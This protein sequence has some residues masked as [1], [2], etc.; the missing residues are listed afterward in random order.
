MNKIRPESKPPAGKNRLS[1]EKSPY[2]LQHAGNPVDWYPW[3]EEAFDRAKSEDKPVFLSI[4]YSTCHWCHVMAHE[5][6][7]DPGVAA[8]MNE[9]FINVKVDREERPDID[10]VYMP[11]CQMVRGNGGWPLTVIL[12]PDKA[13]FFVATYLPRES[14]RGMTGMLDLVPHIGKLWREK[15]REVDDS[16]AELARH[17]ADVFARRPGATAPGAETLDAA[18]AELSARFDEA[19]AGFGRAPKFP[20]PHTL[21]FLLRYWRRTGETRALY[22]VER[23]LGHMARGGICDQVGFGF[24]RYSTDERWFAPHFE[25][26]LY[27]QALLAMAYAECFLATGKAEY[28]RTAEEILLYIMRDMTDPVGGFFSAEDADSEGVEGKYYLWTKSEIEALLGGDDARLVIDLYGVEP[29]GNFADEVAGGNI[30]HLRRP[31]E[32][33]A[34]ELGVEPEDLRLRIDRIRAVLLEARN[35]RVRPHRDDKILADW[36]GLMIAALSVAARAFGADEYS[37]AAEKAARF[38]LDSM[39][40]PEGGLLHRYREGEAAV[41]GN[42]DDH[43]FL[44]WGLMELYET[45]FDAEHLETAVQ[46]T[47]EMIR[48]FADQ[49]HGG[50][51]FTRADGEAMIVR[52]R[53]IYDGAIPSGNSAA[54]VNLVRLARLTG[55]ARYEEHAARIGRVFFEDLSRAPSGYSWYM[56]S[57]ELAEGPSIE[58]VVVGDPASSDTRSMLREVRA[59]YAPHAAILFKTS[60]G[61]DPAIGRIAPFTAAHT[62][63]DGRATAYICRNHACGAPTTNPAD[64]AAVLRPGA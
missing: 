40:T 13:P 64:V 22:M 54:A 53:E 48:L 21:L 27:D 12:T 63:I 11:V 3:G 51:Y 16:S 34:A 46:L 42:L 59:A 41:A 57:V 14:R 29:A 7:E 5:S 32:R 28:R 30:L 43:A 36:N 25:K 50:F 37:A 47:D 26:M 31:L 35:R 24:H 10:A 56:A 23:T 15:R 8:L 58:I 9:A 62:A 4:G 45:T 44:A 6:F 39:R 60:A 1:F 33:A 61:E 20:T 55:D 2:L 19:N 52:T 17:L 18:Y 38:V 49:E